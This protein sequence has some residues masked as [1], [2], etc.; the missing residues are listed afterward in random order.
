MSCVNVCLGS[1][2]QYFVQSCK[3]P[4]ASFENDWFQNKY[5]KMYCYKSFDVDSDILNLNYF[6]LFDIL[7]VNQLQVYNLLFIADNSFGSLIGT[8]LYGIT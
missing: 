8:E 4:L 1:W 7:Y 3:F 6:V 5:Y 2:N